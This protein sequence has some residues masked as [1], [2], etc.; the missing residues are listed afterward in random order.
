VFSCLRILPVLVLSEIHESLDRVHDCINMA[1]AS[2]IR[3]I[4][5]AS[6]ALFP[7]LLEHFPHKSHNI[8]MHKV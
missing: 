3:M 6:T 8:I 2:I 5:S 1:L 4:P 7:F